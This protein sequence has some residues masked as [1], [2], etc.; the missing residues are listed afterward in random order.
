MG[1]IIL[2]HKKQLKDKYFLNNYCYGLK[3]L[4]LNVTAVVYSHALRP[5]EALELKPKIR[6]LIKYCQTHKTDTLK[7]ANDEYVTILH[8]FT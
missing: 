6:C 4:S 3:A 7:Q 2:A 5:E 8:A 1:Y